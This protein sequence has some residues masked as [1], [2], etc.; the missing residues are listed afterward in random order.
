MKNQN[1]NRKGN[2]LKKTS[3][4]TITDK[5]KPPWRQNKQYSSS[6][7]TNSS[8]SELL[9]ENVGSQSVGWRRRS[10]GSS[11]AQ[12]E[13]ERKKSDDKAKNEGQAH[14]NDTEELTEMEREASAIDKP[15][16]VKKK[17]E[18]ENN[19]MQEVSED[20]INKT[21]EMSMKQK[22]QEDEI[23]KTQEGSED[24]INKTQEMSMEEKRKQEDAMNKTQEAL[25]E[26]KNQKK[27]FINVGEV[28]KTRGKADLE[29]DE[30]ISA[31]TQGELSGDIFMR[32]DLL[33]LK[34][35]GSGRRLAPRKL[36][37]VL[38]QKWDVPWS[39]KDEYT[40]EIEERAATRW[41]QAKKRE[42]YGRDIE[43][44]EA[45]RWRSRSRPT[46]DG[47]WFR[48]WEHIR[49]GE[50]YVKIWIRVWRSYGTLW[51]VVLVK[52]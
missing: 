24:E 16:E 2:N 22:K 6:D 10:W 23:N 19:K 31:E 48:C 32:C 40:G 14:R 1:G 45:T 26:E 17:Q 15:L 47:D 30:K 11:Y 33:K 44:Q 27:P 18:E 37:A 21:K 39:D 52:C 3:V 50:A 41:R 5:E 35:G 20:E 42:V 28:G 13:P 12:M 36:G 49:R 25:L 46:K 8:F 51:W 4:S 7:N 29:A 9:R 43:E 34:N 38:W